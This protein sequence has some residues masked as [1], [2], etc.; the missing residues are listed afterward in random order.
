MKVSISMNSAS[1]FKAPVIWFKFTC[2]LNV[3]SLSLGLVSHTKYFLL[4]V[5]LAWNHKFMVDECMQIAEE[6]LKLPITS[7]KDAITST[8][9]S[10]Q[11]PLLCFFSSLFFFF[12][13]ISDCFQFALKR[14]GKDI[15]IFFAH[16]KMWDYHVMKITHLMVNIL[17]WSEW[18]TGYD[19]VNCIWW[20]LLCDQ[21]WHVHGKFH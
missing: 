9:D 10:H 8:I 18:W 12:R 15:L 3:L 16:L 14:W 5:I 6:R 11:V 13:W 4:S 21:C 19:T 17:I 1:M 7:F 20:F 2:T